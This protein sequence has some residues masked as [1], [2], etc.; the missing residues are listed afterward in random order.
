LIKNQA[1][2]EVA[3][4][5]RDPQVQRALADLPAPSGQAHRFVTNKTR[6]NYY[7][8]GKYL[9]AEEQYNEGIE[10]YRDALRRKNP[11]KIGSLRELFS[12]LGTSC[13][14]SGDFSGALELYR[15]AR[16]NLFSTP[17]LS[18]KIGFI[19]YRDEDL[20]SAII[21]FSTRPRGFLLQPERALRHREHPVQEEFP[22]R[23]TML[24]QPGS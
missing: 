16:Q 22:F 11:W 21:E 8:R 4:V 6:K 20:D 7:A 9:D 14:T 13:I 5:K 12:N 15:E 19:A 3:L 23:G 10:L 24:L 1:E 2:E 17:D 18:Y